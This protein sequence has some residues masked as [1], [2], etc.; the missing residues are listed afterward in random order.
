MCTFFEIK[1][2]LDDKTK[3][4]KLILAEM[5]EIFAFQLKICWYQ[6]FTHFNEMHDRKTLPG[7][8]IL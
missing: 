8:V 1:T 7:M 6:D 4:K 2:L 3:A 5:R